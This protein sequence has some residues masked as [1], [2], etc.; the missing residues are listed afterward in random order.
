MP[1]SNG[2]SFDIAPE[3]ITTAANDYVA[4]GGDPKDN[5]RFFFGDLAGRS[6]D[7]LA[8]VN[9]PPQRAPTSAAWRPTRR[10]APFPPS[11]EGTVTSDRLGRVAA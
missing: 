8:G 9:P 6:L 5:P 7:A 2:Q 11:F 1:V 10:A 3:A 4:A